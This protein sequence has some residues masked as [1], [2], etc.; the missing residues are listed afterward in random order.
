MCIILSCTNPIQQ[1]SFAACASA[2]ERPCVCFCLYF[3]CYLL[4][5]TV[6][7]KTI[8]LLYISCDRFYLGVLFICQ[9]TS[10]CMAYISWH[11]CFM[12][13]WCFNIFIFSINFERYTNFLTNF[14]IL[15]K[16]YI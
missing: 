8:V 2:S 3:M 6:S 11:I 10:V 14:I 5:V 13:F 9:S 7:F 1:L 12:Y 15:T 16:V 4:A